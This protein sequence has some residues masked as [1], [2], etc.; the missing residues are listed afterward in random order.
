MLEAHKTD[1]IAQLEK[2]KNASAIMR[3][4]CSCSLRNA[5][6]LASADLSVFRGS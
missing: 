4:I 1:M 6:E 3:K 2:H 5:R